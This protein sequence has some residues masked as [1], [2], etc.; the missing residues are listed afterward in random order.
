MEEVELGGLE[1]DDNDG[2]GGFVGLDDEEY[3]FPS[4]SDREVSS[5]CLQRFVLHAFI[6]SSSVNSF[7]CWL[8]AWIKEGLCCTTDSLHKTLSGFLGIDVN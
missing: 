1:D 7:P 3:K 2:N 4:V 6:Y 5:F 8:Q